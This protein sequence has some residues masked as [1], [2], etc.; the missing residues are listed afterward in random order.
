[1]PDTASE[2]A[3]ERLKI[4]VCSTENNCTIQLK[5]VGNGKDEKI[6]YELQIER[7]SKILGIF[8]KKMKVSADI[9]SE[10]GETKIHKPWWAFIASEPAE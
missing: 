4:K 9:D 3:L 8:Q 2:R 7:H 1:M 5:D 10:T 6:Q